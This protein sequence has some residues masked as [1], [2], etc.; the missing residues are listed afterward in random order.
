LFDPATV[1]DKAGELGDGET[2][3]AGGAGDDGGLAG[4][5]DD[6]R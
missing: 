3:A 1:A 2:N 4:K 6:H 5:I